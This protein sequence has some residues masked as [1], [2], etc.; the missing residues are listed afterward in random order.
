MRYRPSASNL[1]NQP[2]NAAIALWSL[3]I[4]GPFGRSS[5][6]KFLRLVK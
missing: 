5:P 4:N 3:W 1:L 2:Y 6:C